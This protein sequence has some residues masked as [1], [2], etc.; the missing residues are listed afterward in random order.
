MRSREPVP[1]PRERV[2][3][4]EEGGGEEDPVLHPVEIPP[5]F[6]FRRPLRDPEGSGGGESATFTV[7]TT[8]PNDLV[9]G[10]HDRMPAIL[11]RDQEE[12]WIRAG[13]VGPADIS[14]ILAPYPSGEMEAFPV[15]GRVND[16]GSEGP[17]L[18]SP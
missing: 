7:I 9:A 18:I 8:E 10:L 16:P 5:L 17:G 2:L 13:G 3:R 4:V 14:R 6:S 1:C 11:A 15:S 12:S